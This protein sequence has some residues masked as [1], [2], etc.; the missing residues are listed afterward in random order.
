MPLFSLLLSLLLLFYSTVITPL[1][2]NAFSQFLILFFLP[3]ITK[4]MSLPH[5]HPHPYHVSPLSGVSSL[6]RTRHILLRSGQ[7]DFCC[8]CV[9][10][11]WPAHVFC[12]VGSSVSERSHGSRLVETAGLPMGFQ[13]SSAASTLTLIPLQGSPDS[14]HLFVINICFYFSQLLVQPLK[15]QPYLYEHHSIS[16]SV[17]PWILPLRWNPNWSGQWTSYPFSL[18]SIFVPAAPLD[19]NN[20]ESQFLTVGWQPHPS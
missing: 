17:R 11:L 15:G 4:R 9:L 16:N 13:L 12:L 5:P 18:F 8:I 1:P 14:V 10:G 2:V 20:S 3:T 6:L 19:R 7:A